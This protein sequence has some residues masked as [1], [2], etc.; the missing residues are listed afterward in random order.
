MKKKIIFLKNA[1]I[2]ESSIVLYQKYL[3]GW[4]IFKVWFGLVWFGFMAYQ[5][6]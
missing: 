2:N 4:E 1:K 5:P 3:L 6:L